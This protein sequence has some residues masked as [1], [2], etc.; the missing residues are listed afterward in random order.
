MALTKFGKV[1]VS[2]LLHFS[3]VTGQALR[4]FFS[5]LY[6]ILDKDTL[7]REEPKQPKVPPLEFIND[8]FNPM[9]RIEIQLSGISEQLDKL[10]SLQACTECLAGNRIDHL[11]LSP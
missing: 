9:E 8:I 5:N 3:A 6:Q 10:T 1:K 11:Y 2:D 7:Y 4:P